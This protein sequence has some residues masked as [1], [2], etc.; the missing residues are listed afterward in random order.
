ML[1]TFRDLRSDNSPAFV[2]VVKCRTL[3]MGLPGD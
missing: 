2:T 3:E 1:D